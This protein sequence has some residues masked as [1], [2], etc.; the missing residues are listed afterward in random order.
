MPTSAPPASDAT[1]VLSPYPADI[2]WCD[3]ESD[4]EGVS[5][6]KSQIRA[7]FSESENDAFLRIHNP[8]A[9]FV[10]WIRNQLRL[11]TFGHPEHLQ[12]YDRD[13]KSQVPCNSRTICEYA[14]RWPARDGE[15]FGNTGG[16]Q[17]AKQHDDLS[18]DMLFQVTVRDKLK[19]GS[20]GGT[21][22]QPTGTPGESAASPATPADLG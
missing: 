22:A 15:A 17:Y 19:R 14:M 3:C 9:Q 20:V 11:Q 8:P 12:R 16:K 18:G 1:R 13:T 21:D 2:E 10:A 4:S 5:L 7:G 6:E